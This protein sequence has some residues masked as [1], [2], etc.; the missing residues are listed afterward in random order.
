LY[1]RRRNVGERAAFSLGEPNIPSSSTRRD[2]LE[3]SAMAKAVKG[4]GFLDRL[5]AQDVQARRKVSTVVPDLE[6]LVRLIE[7]VPRDGSSKLSSSA[8]GKERPIKSFLPL[9]SWRACAA[10]SRGRSDF[11]FMP[12]W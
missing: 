11:S 4:F 6:P 9:A 12:C 2:F 7:D 10:L 5:S 8:F 1:D 3:T